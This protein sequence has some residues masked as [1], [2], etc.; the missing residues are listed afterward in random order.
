MP[1]PFNQNT[2]ISFQSRQAGS[3]AFEVRDL[4]GRKVAAM[5][6]KAGAGENRILFDGSSLSDGVYIYTLSNGTAVMTDRI[7]VGR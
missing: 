1:N 3:Y 7:V 5:E 2:T 4:T 6:I